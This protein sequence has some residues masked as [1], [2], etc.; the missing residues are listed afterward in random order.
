MG[1]IAT[2]PLWL[3]PVVPT[4]DGPAHLYNA[5]L[6]LHLD[7]P[8]LQPRRF[9]EVNAFTSNW[10]A[11]GPLVPLLAVLPPS[12]AE[13]VFLAAIVA[14]LV[15]AAAALTARLG[16]DPVLAGASGG[17]LAHGG[18]LAGG[19]TGFLFSFGLGLAACAAGARAPGSAPDSRGLR[20]AITGMAA[21]LAL[22]FF[23]HLTGAVV[24]A[25]I[26]VLLCAGRLGEA[27]PPR[28]RLVLAGAPLVLLA[29]L[30]L[31]RWA[32]A[33]GRAV[34]LFRPAPAADWSRLLALPT[35][36]WW[37]AYS[38]IDRGVGGALLLLT[39]GMLVARGTRRGA[40]TGSARTLAWGA[41]AALAAW[42]VVP[43]AVGSAS[44]P[45]DRLVLPLL[46][47]PLPW[48]TSAGL[49][50]RGFFRAALV[51][52][53]VGALAHRAVQYR[54]WGGLT[55]KVVGANRELPEGHLLVQP[56]P[57]PLP[58]AVS[59]L[60]HVW[61][62]VGIDRRA[63]ALDNVQ[64]LRVGWFPVSFTPEGEALASAWRDGGRV[65]RGAVVLRYE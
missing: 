21:A 34:P 2:L 22:L 47:L 52:L 19:S 41:G 13:K 15:L 33:S 57:P 59:P 12:L 4:A 18:L 31:G 3:A 36:A 30:L 29:V 25:S 17:V 9:V 64:A 42:A 20:Q 49:P 58:L 55:T 40:S 16:G 62:R 63:F 60:R 1:A 45:V 5:W 11:V 65:P 39:A 48:A 27:W 54:S 24:A 6:L 32:A 23:V 51:L 8:A 10:G 37:E 50:A 26:W 28:R 7:D 35:G 38:A 43:W 14:L 46:L 44:V 53:L 56:P 61:G